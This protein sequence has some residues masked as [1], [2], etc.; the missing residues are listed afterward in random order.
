MKGGWSE[1]VL[2]CAAHWQRHKRMLDHLNQEAIIEAAGTR[3][4]ERLYALIERGYRP[5]LED[6]FSGA[7]WLNHPSK[8]CQHPLL[9]LYPSGLVVSSGKSDDFRFYRDDEDEPRFQ[10]FL[11]SVPLPTLW[12][13][14][15]A[16]RTNAAAW[17]I[18]VTVCG[19]SAL[20][21]YLVLRLFGFN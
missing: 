14:T 17:A 10:K 2:S 19:G 18:I 1:A 21:T 7:I 13:R 16:W 3:T 20:L 4:F 15:R 9:F 8:R 5:N 11:R 12:D 6:N